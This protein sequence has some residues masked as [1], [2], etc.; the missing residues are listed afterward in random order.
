FYLAGESQRLV[1]TNIS[2]YFVEA[3]STLNE[4]LLGDY[5]IKKSDNPRLKRWVINQ[6]LDTY[7]HNLVTHLLEE[8]FQCQV[9]AKVEVGEA[10][11]AD[12]LCA[13]KKAAIAS[14]W[15]DAA[16]IDDGAGLTWMRQPHYY[17][18]L[19][20]YTYSA[21]LTVATAVAVKMKTDSEQTACE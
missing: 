6:L 7:Y 10:L 19:Y 18:G 17:M 20:P 2:T 9:Y 21:G 16:V 3:P 15:G 14:F 4:L 13:E 8:E 5:L 11:T 12:V 1:N